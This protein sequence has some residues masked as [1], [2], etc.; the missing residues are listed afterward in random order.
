MIE[1]QNRYFNFLF[2]HKILLYSQIL[3]WHRNLPLWETEL[4]GQPS[5]RPSGSSQASL[6][7]G[8]TQSMAQVG[9]A[10]ESSFLRDMGA[11]Q[12]GN[13]GSPSTCTNL[14]RT[15]LPRETLLTQF[16]FPSPSFSYGRPACLAVCRLS[17]PAHPSS[18]FSFTS[19]CLHPQG[20]S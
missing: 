14:L 15:A 18:P 10:S 5:Y 12:P 3:W 13:E 7:R 19:T 11:P 20:T 1:F 2:K 4:T 8:C 9:G 16:F 6:H 17:L